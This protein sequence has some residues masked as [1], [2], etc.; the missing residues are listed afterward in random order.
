MYVF[1]FKQSGKKCSRNPES[2]IETASIQ[3]TV[4]HEIADDGDEVWV[5]R[6]HL[7]QEAV[8]PPSIIRVVPV[9]RAAACDAR[10]R[11]ALATSSPSVRGE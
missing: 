2:I 3:I 4:T 8:H 1:Y 10:N 7:N 9:I 11:T 5:E 6:M